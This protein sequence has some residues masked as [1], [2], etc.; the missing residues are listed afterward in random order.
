MATEIATGNAALDT[1]TTRGWLVGHFIDGG[2]RH[3]YDVEIKWG[4]HKAGEAR[5]DWVINEVR[6]T[7]TIL[8][9]GKIEI[10]FRDQTVTLEK[11][12]DYVMW[13][14]DTDHKWRMLEDSTVIT[15]RWPSVTE[16]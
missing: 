10:E 7:I 16:A 8:I 4:V 2:L 13:G 9:S 6:S 15:I 14:F 11:Q 12:G 5:T 1:T 3:D